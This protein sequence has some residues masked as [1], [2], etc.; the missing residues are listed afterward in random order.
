MSV[1]EFNEVVL[2]LFILVKVNCCKT[3]RIAY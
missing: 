1:Y 2:K 3:S